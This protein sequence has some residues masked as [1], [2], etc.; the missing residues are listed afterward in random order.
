MKYY[1]MALEQTLS[2]GEYNEF[3]PAVKKFNDFQSAQVYYLARLAELANSPSHSYAQ[4][5][6]VN[7]KFAEIDNNTYTIREYHDEDAVEE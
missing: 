7:S 2:N 4:L 6:I 1:V 5:K 3:A